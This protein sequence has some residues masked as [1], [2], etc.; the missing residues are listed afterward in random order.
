MAAADEAKSS[1]TAI[2]VPCIY[3]RERERGSEF[4]CHLEGQQEAKGCDLWAAGGRSSVKEC[5]EQVTSV[6]PE[7]RT[8]GLRRRLWLDPRAAAAAS[9]PAA[10]S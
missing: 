3:E 4:A 10:A 7:P 8:G 1:A 9:D 6:S 2:F 5:A